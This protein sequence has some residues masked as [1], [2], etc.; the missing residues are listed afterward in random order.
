MS[1]KER[2]VISGYGAATPAGNAEGFRKA[3]WTQTPFIRKFSDPERCAFL[4]HPVPIATVPSEIV[5]MSPLNDP[6][7]PLEF[8]LAATAL[9]EALGNVSAEE[10]KN[11]GLAMG[12]TALASGYDRVLKDSK[13]LT[14]LSLLA[15][16]DSLFWGHM[17]ILMAAKFGLGGLVETSPM[18]CAGGA[19]SLRIAKNLLESDQ[20]SFALA[21]ASE[22]F[23]KPVHL[24]SMMLADR[25]S[26]RLNSSH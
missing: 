12:M 5:A 21:G 20:V 23:S 26:T 8:K 22:C 18:N 10:R 9:K 1:S 25:K 6:D 11:C 3:V 14:A 24:Q 13:L 15:F 16:N 19:E 2:L 17:L 4:P 7:S